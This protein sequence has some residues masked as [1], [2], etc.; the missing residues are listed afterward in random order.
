M[1]YKIISCLL[2]V[3][4]LLSCKS[5]TDETKQYLKLPVLTVDTCTAIT[6]KDY[7]GTIE[8]KVN[9]EI[10]SQVEGTL[11]EIYV[12][13]G[14]Y[15]EEGQKLFKIDPSPYTEELNNQIANENIEKAKLK[16]AKLE[17]DRLR[18]LIENE[19]IAEVQ[20]EA[21]MANYEVAQA[22]L[23]RASAAVASAQINLDRTVIEAPVQGYI[24]M[25]PKRIGNLVTR[26]EKTPL[27]VL[28]DVSDVYVYFSMSE[29]DYLYFT[30]NKTIK[31][32]ST[33]NSLGNILPEA[34]L[35]LADGVEYQEKGIVDAVSGQVNRSTGSI[36]LRASFPN[37]SE[38]MRSGNTG[39]I[40]L[41]ESKRGV[42]LVPQ[43]SIITIQDR[44]FV[45]TI[46]ENDRA[47]M[48][49]IE[50]NGVSEENY[51][52]SKGL[53]PGDKIILTGFH[54]VEEGI[55]ISPKEER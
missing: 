29:S 33:R 50:I 26:D 43:E 5:K 11:Q 53:K 44:K 27:T 24:G 28:S 2:A 20:L 15:V 10:R 12:D 47:R 19:V 16:N 13:E 35:Y 37:S 34:T 55:L 8:G 18:P 30:R 25:I 49:P 45:Y 21:E 42:I 9:V 46:D 22:S 36:S 23:A 39:T 48:E 17:V 31:N 1:M 40:Q 6:V 51:I 7:I 14:Q 38:V 32:D 41:K 52:I 3:A 4:F 54:K